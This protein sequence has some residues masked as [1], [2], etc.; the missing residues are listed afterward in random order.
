[1]DQNCEKDI[2]SLLTEH[3]VWEE[4]LEYK[5]SGGHMSRREDEALAAFI[6]NKEYL[7]PAENI[8]SGGPFPHPSVTVL[9]KKGSTKKRTVFT[10]PEAENNLLKLIGWLLG[11]YD[12]IFPDCLYSFRRN[13]GVKRAVSDLKSVSGI[14]SMYSYKT[15]IHDY[16]GSVRPEDI[17]PMLH[18]VLDEKDSRLA[19]YLEAMLSDPIALRDGEEIVLPKGIM[20]GTPTSAFI[21]DLFLT[22]LDRSFEEREIPY[23][24]YSDD[25]IVFA[26]SGEEL[27]GYI[28][29]ILSA[30]DAKGL[31]V[32]PAKEKRTLPGEPWEY[33]GFSVDGEK[34]DISRTSADKLKKKLKRKADALLRWKE[35]GEKKGATSERAVRA[36]FK[37]CSK[38]LFDNPV[39]NE[40]T[41]GRWYFPVITTDETLHELDAYLLDLARYIA[42]GRWSAS[43]YKTGYEEMKKLGYQSLV[44]RYYRFKKG[45][46]D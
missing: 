6:E 36:F 30:L 16:F 5:R 19:G 38:K 1:M 4:F 2:L 42:C 22:E 34:T 24:R 13:T 17:I 40:I 14:A 39:K 12:C 15:D 41:W 37:Y 46:I 29:E 21:A 45:N 31:T 9:N 23:A 8:I 27:E 10:F 32:N 3:S 28:D 35:R 18:R 20:A 11:R 7:K 26:E 33:L 44:N 43:R 25:I